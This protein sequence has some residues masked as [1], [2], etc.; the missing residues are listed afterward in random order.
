[1]GLPLLQGVERLP[2]GR[3]FDTAWKS[4][5]WRKLGSNAIPLPRASHRQNLS[6]ANF[7]CVLWRTASLLLSSPAAPGRAHFLNVC[8]PGQQEESCPRPWKTFQS[9]HPH[10]SSNYPLL[11]G[12]ITLQLSDE[13]GMDVQVHLGVISLTVFNH[14][15]A[16]R[17]EF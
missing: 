15:K 14:R 9:D 4:R 8:L 10:V 11:K 5:C 12:V 16:K 6:M 1:M 3:W 13:R 2:V 17:T 7:S